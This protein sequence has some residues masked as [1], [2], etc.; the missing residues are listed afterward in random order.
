M[1][2]A[3]IQ[4][5]N[6]ITD[7]RS[8]RIGQE[9]I[10]PVEEAEACG[11]WTP[12]PEA[13]ALPFTVTNV[14]FTNSPLGGLWS[15]GEI[16][17]STGTELEQ[18]GVT[19]SLLDE[20]GQVLAQEQGTSGSTC[21]VPG[22]KAPFAMRFAAPPQTFSSYQAMPW[23]GVQGYVGSY[24]LDLEVRDAE[25]S[26]ERYRP[27]PSPAT[28]RTSGPR[29]LVEVAVTVT[30]YDSL[31]RVIGDAPG[32]ARAQRHSTGADKPPSP[33]NSR[34]PAGPSQASTRRRWGDGWPPPLPKPVAA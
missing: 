31:G 13:T 2:V 22:D 8:L 20:Q 15:F 34:L 4:D 21:C 3:G 11:G 7:P 14:T 27:I 29:M 24:Y 1:S 6:G 16:V 26:G 23:K 17:N 12:T 5:A 28:S 19:I 9:L 10:I 30:L 25:G 33:L 18:A 32:G